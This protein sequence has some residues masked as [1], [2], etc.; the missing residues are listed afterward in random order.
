MKRA[1][2]FCGSSPRVWGTRNDC[3]ANMVPTRFIPT[4][5][6][7][8]F[9]LETQLVGT[10]VHPHACG[11]HA[12]PRFHLCSFPGSS[13]RVWGTRIAG[14]LIPV[15]VRFIPTRVGNTRARA[16]RPTADPVHPHACGEH[17]LFGTRPGLVVGSSPRVWGTRSARRR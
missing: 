10:A 7:N 6:G 14:Q 16:L 12:P 17:D 15:V 9:G 5:V 2:L 1:T 8:T 11:E 13:P 3:R 4:R